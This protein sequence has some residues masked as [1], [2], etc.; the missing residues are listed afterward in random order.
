M[1]PFGKGLGLRPF[2][3]CTCSM[4]TQPAPPPCPLKY[5]PVLPLLTC[6]PDFKENPPLSTRA[7]VYIG[8]D[9]SLPLLPPF[10]QQSTVR[11][12]LLVELGLRWVSSVPAARMHRRE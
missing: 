2:K 10:L 7:E 8:V 12:D 3:S 1:C 6:Q 4:R 5:L 9:Y 11:R